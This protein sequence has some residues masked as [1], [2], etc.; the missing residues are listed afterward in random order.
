MNSTVLFSNNF[1]PT[2][3][4]TCLSLF[5]WLHILFPVA[6]QDV[7]LTLFSF[8]TTRARRWRHTLLFP[9]MTSI[10]PNYA[11]S[12]LHLYTEW[13]SML[14]LLM[15]YFTYLATSILKSNLPPSPLSQKC[16]ATTSLK[17][18]ISINTEAW[19]RNLWVTLDS[20]LFH[21]PHLSSH[22]ALLSLPLK[23]V[24][25]PSTAK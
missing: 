9:A 25:I 16:S 15:A 1:P 10:T 12:V 21:T 6:S 14:L 18:I 7:S 22:Q 3:L 20:S 13:V 23:A 19:V 4:N 24:H 2:L 17:P 5:H 11:I 8:H